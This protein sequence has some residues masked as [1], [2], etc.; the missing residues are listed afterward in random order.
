MASFMPIYFL[1]RADKTARITAE[2]VKKP[3]MLQQ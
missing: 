2:A 1:N 3:P